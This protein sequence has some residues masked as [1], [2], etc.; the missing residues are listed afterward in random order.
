MKSVVDP[1]HAAAVNRALTPDFTRAR[2]IVAAFEKARAEGKD[3]AKLD[4]ALIEVPVYAAAKRVLESAAHSSPPPKR[5][6]G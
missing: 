1:S 2:R 4:G 3:R 5:K 6:Q